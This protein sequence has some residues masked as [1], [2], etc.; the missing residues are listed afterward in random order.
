MDRESAVKFIHANFGGVIED[1]PWQD[2]PEYTVFDIPI[3]ENGLLFSQRSLTLR[4]QNK[5]PKDLLNLLRQ[6]S[7]FQLTFLT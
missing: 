2:S 5:I 7:I 6:N 1:S 3:I 4:S